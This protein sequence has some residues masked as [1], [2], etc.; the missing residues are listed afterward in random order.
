[1]RASDKCASRAIGFS[2]NSAGIHEDHVGFNGLALG[3]SSQ[4]ARDGFAV[5]TRRAA[6]EILDGKP[7][8]NLSVV[9]FRV[10]CDSPEV[11]PAV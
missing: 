11:G 5:S 9:N 10:R 6:A 7:R 3:K 1:M 8:H 4:M 2:R